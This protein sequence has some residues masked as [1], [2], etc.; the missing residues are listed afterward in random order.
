[1]NQV[2]IH[3][4]GKQIIIYDV[5][6]FAFLTKIGT[7][8]ERNQRGWGVTSLDTEIRKEGPRLEEPPKVNLPVL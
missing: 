7:Q 3:A 1:M 6:F 4:K 5:L 8:V 2:V